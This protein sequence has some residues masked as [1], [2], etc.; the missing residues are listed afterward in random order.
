[1]FRRWSPEEQRVSMSDAAEGREARPLL[2]HDDNAT[3]GVNQVDDCKKPPE[4]H[5]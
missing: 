3:D 2:I 4:Q 1:M 5:L